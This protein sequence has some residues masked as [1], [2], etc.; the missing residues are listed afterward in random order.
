MAATDEPV[1]AAL[2]RAWTRLRAEDAAIPAIHFDL[3]PGRSSSCGQIEFNTAAVIVLNLAPGWDGEPETLDQHKLSGTQILDYLLHHAAHAIAGPT[4]SQEG[5]WHS[6]A[7]RDAAQRLGLTVERGGIGAG[8]WNRTA[9]TGST[10]SRYRHEI[11]ALDKAMAQW[12][13]VAARKRRR[14]PVSLRC[15]CTPPRVLSTRPTTAATG[16]IRC[17]ICGQ[18]FLVRSA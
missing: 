18:D 4:T 16:Q 14:G 11:A 5:R 2:E 7:Y 15:S 6:E 10:E 17:G 9:I 12:E 3:E 1:L 8:G 13:P